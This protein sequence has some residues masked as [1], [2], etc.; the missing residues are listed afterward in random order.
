MVWREGGVCHPPRMFTGPELTCPSTR[1]LIPHRPA[2][3]APVRRSEQLRY[4]VDLVSTSVNEYLTDLVDWLIGVPLNHKLQ[5]QLGLFKSTCSMLEE[6]SRS[7]RS[8]PVATVPCFLRLTGT[9]LTS[10]DFGPKPTRQQVG[11]QTPRNLAVATAR[12]QFLPTFA[13]SYRLPPHA[14]DC[15]GDSITPP[16]LPDCASPPS[17]W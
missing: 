12:A 7:N 10:A 11:V 2:C 16:P 8:L 14:A 15:Q 5:P 9:A 1:E 17:P 6:A 4:R 13:S 3:P